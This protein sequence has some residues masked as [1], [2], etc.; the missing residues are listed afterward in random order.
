MYNP[1]S[2]PFSWPVQWW[3]HGTIIGSLCIV[4]ARILNKYFQDLRLTSH[5]SP[6]IVL[7]SQGSYPNQLLC[8]LSMCMPKDLLSCFLIFNTFSQS[9]QWCC[10]PYLNLSFQNLLSV[11][12]S[13]YFT[14]THCRALSLLFSP[15]NLDSSRYELKYNPKSL[16]PSK[17]WICICIAVVVLN[18]TVQNVVSPVSQAPSCL[19]IYFGYY[20]LSSNTLGT[21]LDCW[22]SRQKSQFLHQVYK[23]W[24][25]ISV[26]CFTLRTSPTAQSGPVARFILWNP[27]PSIDILCL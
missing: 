3:S 24:F 27:K 26:Q 12:N 14:S 7:L 15:I 25:R 21:D 22:S 1:L 16:R 18:S 4:L 2:L 23:V 17:S 13:S 8:A 9:I 11:L 10:F 19:C 6:K 20:E 5:S